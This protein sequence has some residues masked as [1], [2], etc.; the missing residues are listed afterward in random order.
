M[1]RSNGPGLPGP[2]WIASTAT[3]SRTR[4]N[5]GSGLKRSRSIGVT[6]GHWWPSVKYATL[7][8]IHSSSSG[9][10]SSS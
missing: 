9:I 4:D 2:R 1:T 10:P 3:P 5:G 8:R 7:E 6:N